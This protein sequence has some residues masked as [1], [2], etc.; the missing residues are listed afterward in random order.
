M[1]TKRIIAVL[2]VAS[3]LL[4]TTAL[5]ATTGRPHLSA[6][7]STNQF[8]P[9]DDGALSITLRNQG[10][11]DT[12]SNPQV[13]SQVTTARGVKV[14]V[15]SG[16]APISVQSG[17]QIVK[18]GSIQDGGAVPTQFQISVDRDAEPGT[19]QVPVTVDYTY[20]SSVSD[21]GK[22][23]T[24][25]EERTLY[26]PITIKEVPQF[27]IV[28]SKSNLSIG[29]SGPVTVTIENIGH[30]AAHNAYISLQS[31]NGAVSTGASSGAASS[32]GR[33]AAAS[34][35]NAA[36][37]GSSGSSS[38][39]A[40]G[41][42]VSLGGA[43]TYIGNWEAGEN[44]TVTIQS[45]VA[46][47]AEVRN[48]TLKAS[49]NY[50]NKNGNDQQSNPL[51][52]GVKPRGE[53]T[54]AV[55]N[56]SSTL[57]VGD[58]GT[59]SGTIVNTGETTVHN[60]V[61]DF[62]TQNQNINAQEPE[63]AIGTL[64][65]GEKAPFS[66]KAEVT[67]SADAG[68]RQFTLSAKYRDNNNDRHQADSADVKAN[69]GPARKDFKIKG[70]HTTLQQGKNGNL[71]VVVTNNRNETLRDVSAK[72]FVDSPLST[73]NSEAFIAKLSPGQSKRISFD[74]SVGGN[75]MAKSYPAK[76]DFQYE[77]PDGDT[78]L[79]QTYKVPVQVTEPSG[80]GGFPPAWVTGLVGV[81]I[82]AA[83]GYYLYRRS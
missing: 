30:A 18:G 16:S 12:S 1:N 6:S 35:A 52:F 4:P 82:L 70:I 33:S 61:V 15:E 67:D 31:S 45:S 47:N 29:E 5:A 44:K 13:N 51:V 14:S 68:P 2:V 76:M 42:A 37:S 49:V 69:I 46:S 50:E 39:S 40:S 41:S 32:A 27:E 43:S 36:A 8:A 72:V 23:S 58:T 28:S 53:Q 26:V 65:P 54:F 77:L 57:R 55:R 7:T 64:K 81:V 38:G 9:G 17:P 24:G 75:T 21:S 3:L 66:F 78:H 48:Y 56:V 25:T 11:I 74:L 22:Y 59:L 71:S 83:A 79:S 80:N 19:Y 60:L 73:S 34:N 62:Q 10:E 20:T 63:Y